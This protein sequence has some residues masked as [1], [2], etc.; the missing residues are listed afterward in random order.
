MSALPEEPFEEAWRRAFDGA[1]QP[2]EDALWGRI[3]RQLPPERGRRRPVAWVWY[4]AASL[5]ALLLAGGLGWWAGRESSPDAMPA[6]QL[7]TTPA[8]PALR[9]ETTPA[10]SAESARNPARGS[11]ENGA[12]SP[13]IASTDV[14]K[15]KSTRSNLQ[16]GAETRQSGF[17]K[18]ALG[19]APV[20][21][22]SPGQTDS[23]ALEV[24]PS[25]LATRPAGRAATGEVVAMNSADAQPNRTVQ[26]NAISERIP[27]AL[28]EPTLVAPTNLSA[29][30]L[31]AKNTRPLRLRFGPLGMPLVLPEPGEARPAAT[32][33]SAERRFYASL[34]ASPTSFDPNIQLRSSLVSAVVSNT[35]NFANVGATLRSSADAASSS[36]ALSYRVG[37]R[38]GWRVSRRWSLESGLEYLDG[39]SNLQS[40]LVLLDRNT[41]TASSLFENALGNKSASPAPNGLSANYDLFG[42]TNQNAFVP[43]ETQ[44]RNRYQ[45]VSVPLQL[46]YRLWPE[47]R[48]EGILNAGLSGDFFLNNTLAPVGDASLQ[49]VSYTNA[50]GVYRRLLWSGTAGAGLR[51]RLA[52]RWGLL[53]NGSYR[54][55]LTPGVREGLGAQTSP[56]E[57]G[58]GLRLDFRF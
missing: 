9:P 21:S 5:L 29:D 47:K 25:R 56:R 52:P 18:K 26:T 50:D 32:Q 41:S 57:F 33:P 20:K 15:T 10:A 51:Y 34:G 46:G 19:D 49:R 7:A 43:R 54:R 22:L 4:A 44:L 23:G 58:A 38:L 16:L 1:S 55:A 39:Q 48:I 11:A 3:E 27:P 31:T 13:S 35:G 2:P 40:G 24:E 30:F 17:S 8:K 45:Y 36:A 53:L 42:L 14:A 12:S 28:A 37:G 6:N